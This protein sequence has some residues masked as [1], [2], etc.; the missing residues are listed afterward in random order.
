MVSKTKALAIARAASD[1]K[2][3]DIVTLKMRKV[4]GVCDYFVIAS[5]KSTTQTRAISDHIKSK[6]KDSSERLWHSEGERE[7]SWIVLDYGDV[8]GHIF[9]EDTR[10]F[11]AL[12]KL[13]HKAE[14]ERFREGPPH[15]RR[16]KR[17]PLKHLEKRAVSGKK[18]AIGRRR[19]SPKKK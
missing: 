3:L 19:R 10:R 16:K 9:L 15:I 13:W 1:K 12:E 11:Y 14:R 18:R 5:G 2:A 17:R 8:V 7:G 6:L 4:S